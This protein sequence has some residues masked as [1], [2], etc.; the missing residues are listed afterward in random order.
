MASGSKITPDTGARRS[1]NSSTTGTWVPG[2][3]GSTGSPVPQP[4]PARSAAQRVPRSRER[5]LMAVLEGSACRDDMAGRGRGDVAGLGAVAVAVGRVLQR[6][7]AQVEVLGGVR[8]HVATVAGVEAGEQG[9][10]P[11][12][13]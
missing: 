7:E 12:Q 11:R 5:T 3:A 2:A 4:E 1:G 6:L 9:A 8:L 13:V 10:L